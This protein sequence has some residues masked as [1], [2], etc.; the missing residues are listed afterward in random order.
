M[1]GIAL[2][3]SVFAVEASQKL[4]TSEYPSVNQAVADAISALVNLGYG[5][6]DA[7]GAVAQAAQRL[8]EGAGVEALI[9][10]GLVELAAFEARK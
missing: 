3:S 2:G 8:G 10:D 9:K 6:S 5:R 4:S 1:G 7:Y